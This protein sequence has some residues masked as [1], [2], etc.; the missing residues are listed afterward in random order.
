ME[1]RSFSPDGEQMREARQ[2]LLNEVVLARKEV[3]QRE[4]I[5]SISM[6]PQLEQMYFARCTVLKG[7]LSKENEPL[8]S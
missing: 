1:G 7:A 6:V 4:P 2:N 8:V 5:H 3:F